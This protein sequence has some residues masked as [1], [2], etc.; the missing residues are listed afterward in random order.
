MKKTLIYISLLFIVSACGKQKQNIDDPFS[1][2]KNTLDSLTTAGITPG[3]SMSVFTRDSIIMVHTSGYANLSDS[4]KVKET[5]NFEAASLS[6]PILAHIYLKHFKDEIPLDTS[7]LSF[8][9]QS[10]TNN[11]DYLEKVSPFH[12]LSH[13]SGLP[14]WRA[15]PDTK[16]KSLSEVFKKTDSLNFKFEPGSKFGY[17]GEGYIWLQGAIE[18]VSDKPFQQI[19]SETIFAMAKANSSTFI[20]PKI[21]K[22]AS[23][24]YNEDNERVSKQIINVTLASASL[25][26]NAVEYAKM[27]QHY[28]TDESSLMDPVIEV[29]TLDNFQIKWAPGIGIM[30]NNQGAEYLFHWGDNG[31]FKSYL[32]YDKNNDLGFVYFTNSS[33][34]LKIRN[35]IIDKVYNKKIPMW[36]EDYEQLK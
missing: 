16:A 12:V 18:K 2:L 30:D 11:T 5:T 9:D 14:N 8:Y 22:N 26:S 21:D 1:G 19:A 33:N 24:P 35:I 31:S 32:I 3:I 27:F 20:Y 29:D 7:L 28:I 25:H 15:M 23:I 34:G 10:I 4:V 13:Q 17:S 6:K 36:P